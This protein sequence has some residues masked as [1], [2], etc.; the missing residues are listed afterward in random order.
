[1][2]I[3]DNEIWKYIAKKYIFGIEQKP[4]FKSKT[5]KQLESTPLNEQIEYVKKRFI[6]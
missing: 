4:C 2:D 5:V 1:M 6:Q 3:T